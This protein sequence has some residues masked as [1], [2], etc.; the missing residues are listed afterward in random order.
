M[1]G[2]ELRPDLQDNRWLLNRG[3]NEPGL[4]LV[5]NVDVDVSDKVVPAIVSS[6][7]RKPVMNTVL[8]FDITIELYGGKDTHHASAMLRTIEM[9]YC[10]PCRKPKSNYRK[11]VPT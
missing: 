9:N 5:P 10:N 3:A 8:Y 2:G 11:F 7:P 1:I 6:I 4:G